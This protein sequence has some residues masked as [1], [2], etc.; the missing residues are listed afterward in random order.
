MYSP[1]SLPLASGCDALSTATKGSRNSSV[2]AIPSGSGIGR[3][4]PTS[5]DSSNTASTTSRLLISFKFRCTEG[6]RWRK[7]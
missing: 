5:M 3:I 7:A 4:R 1:C 6:K 2:Q